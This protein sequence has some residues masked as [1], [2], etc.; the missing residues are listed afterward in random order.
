VPD[1]T[2]VETRV[3]DLVE[4]FSFAVKYLLGQGVRCIRCGEPVGMTRGELLGASGIEDKNEVVRQ[5]KAFLA[6]AGDA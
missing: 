4:S 2:T 3:E 6:G 5:L 1:T